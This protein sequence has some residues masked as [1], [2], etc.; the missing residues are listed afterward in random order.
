MAVVGRC[1]RIWGLLRGSFWA[2]GCGYG[3]CYVAVLGREALAVLGREIE[4]MGIVVLQFWGGMF[5]IW[6]LLG[7]SFGG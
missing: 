5:R 2:G 6:G 4:D 7:C 1:V 3:G